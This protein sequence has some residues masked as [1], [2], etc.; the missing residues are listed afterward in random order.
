MKNKK[1]NKKQPEMEL[2]EK[3]WVEPSFK[4]WIS[5]NPNMVLPEHL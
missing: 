5:E 3:F 1:K 4:K 2:K